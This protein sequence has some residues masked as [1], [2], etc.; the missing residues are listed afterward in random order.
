MGLEEAGRKLRYEFLNMVGANG[1]NKIATG[2]TM[3]DNLETMLLCLARGAGM[4]GLAGIPPRRG[5]LIRP[6][7]FL[8]RHQTEAYCDDNALGYL[9]DSCNEDESFARNMVRKRI[10]PLLERVNSEAVTHAATSAAILGEEDALLDSIAA[11]HLA[12]NEVHRVGP[13]AFLE[14]QIATEWRSMADLPIALVRRCIRIGTA[15]YGGALGHAATQALAEAMHRGD[16]A[17]FTAEGGYVGVTVSDGVWSVT[18][19]E[20]QQAFREILTIPGETIADDLGWVLAAWDGS[21]KPDPLHGE[22]D[23]DSVRGSL[24]ARSIQAKDK[25]NPPGRGS[26]KPLAERLARA[27]AGERVRARLPVVCDIVGPVW[28]PL[29]GVD[30]RCAVSE[31]TKKRIALRFGSIDDTSGNSPA[32]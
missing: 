6:I 15:L 29:V 20:T 27:G 14:T 12:A 7:L 1:Y 31:V 3:S 19:C 9:Q 4:R 13:L 17:S 30:R 21:V 28:A 26:Q 2:H 11:A 18:R 25:I 10:V 5:N 16:K 8:S 23:A 32:V 22:L 24:Y